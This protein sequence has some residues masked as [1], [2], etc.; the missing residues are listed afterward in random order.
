MKQV[1]ALFFFLLFLQAV[2]QSDDQRRKHF[3]I[4]KDIAIEGYDPVS[5]FDGNPVEG[6]KLWTASFLE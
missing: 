6:N 5:Y 3:N 4:K 1:L 2:G